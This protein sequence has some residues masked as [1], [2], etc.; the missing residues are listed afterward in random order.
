MNLDSTIYILW[1]TLLKKISWWWWL[2]LKFYY[3]LTPRTF[4]HWFVHAYVYAQWILCAQLYWI[5]LRLWLNDRSE[6]LYVASRLKNNICERWIAP[7]VYIISIFVGDP[8]QCTS[9]RI[10]RVKIPIWVILDEKHT[11]QWNLILQI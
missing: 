1:Y 6:N 7:W 10:Q 8:L 5:S 11:Y 4:V 9:T 3:A 2:V